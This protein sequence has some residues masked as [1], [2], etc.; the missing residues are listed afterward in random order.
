MRKKLNFYVSFKK[1]EEIKIYYKIYKIYYI[2][3]KN[4][5]LKLFHYY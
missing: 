3:I 4:Y 2:L 1:F 5:K